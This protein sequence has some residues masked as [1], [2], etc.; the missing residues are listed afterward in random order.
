[1]KHHQSAQVHCVTAQQE[2]DWNVAQL[3]SSVQQA[4]WRMWHYLEPEVVLG[5]A[6]YDALHQPSD[7]NTRKVLRQAGGGAVLVGPWM[8]S[9]SVVLP[10]THPLATSSPVLSYRWLGQCFADVLCMSQVAAHAISPEETRVLKQVNDLG[11]ELAWACY[12]GLSPWEVVVGQR[13]LVG[14]AQ[15]RRSTGILLVAGLLLSQ[16][17]WPVLC[18]AMQRPITQALQLHDRT[19][20]LQEETHTGLD[21]SDITEPLS[22]ALNAALQGVTT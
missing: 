20:S 15:V 3:S 13:K 7:N 12:G 5:C 21:L 18:G 8:L 19:T 4:Q 9:V 11:G 22:A 2:Q 1:M 6:Q 17:D 16:P 10:H 14:L